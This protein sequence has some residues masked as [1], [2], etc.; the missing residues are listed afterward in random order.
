MNEFDCILSHQLPVIEKIIQ[1]ETWLEGERRGCFVPSSDKVVR[2]NVCLV[3]LRVGAEVREEAMRKV[4]EARR[5]EASA[6]MDSLQD[7]AA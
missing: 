6:A 4:A 2:A 1:D 5:A 3:I 7:C